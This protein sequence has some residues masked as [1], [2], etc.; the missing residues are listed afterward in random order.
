MKTT[1]DILIIGAGVIGLALARELRRRGLRRICMIERGSVGREASYAAAGMLAPN[2]ECEVVDD[3]HRFCDESRRSYPQFAEEL[4]AETCIDIE[5]DRSGTLYAAFSEADR[6]HLA[7]RYARQQAAGIPV[8]K[9]SADE[10]LELEP[11]LATNINESLYFPTDWQVENRRL[12]AALA[13]FAAD[14]GITI[15]E[16]R[17]VD[18]LIVE[19][20]SVKGAVAGGE[21]IFAGS[22]VLATGAWTSLIKIGNSPMPL[23][24]RPIKGQMISFQPAERV[25]KHVIYSP[26]G[27][28]VPRADGR[29]LAGA[30]VEDVG[31]DSGITL[32]ATESL[33]AAAVEIAPCLKDVDIA[34]TWAGLRPFAADGL[35]VIGK[36]G[37]LDGVFVAT[38]HYRNGIL[39]APLTAKI[40][41]ES[42]ANE[43]DSEYFTLFGPHRFA[44]ERSAARANDNSVRL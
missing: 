25:F 27:Y 3:F 36:I 5:L 43:A 4:L 15:I 32:S 40:L 9:L 34:E 8:E 10:T 2:A 19:N 35:P 11:C 1:F 31:F 12:L 7:L 16:R 22:T 29:I 30:T 41:A 26:R 38:A 20:G 28:L 14:N 42:I 21:P 23:N 44:G 33:Q 18:S 17:A 6:A 37:E 39:L 13:K 24:V